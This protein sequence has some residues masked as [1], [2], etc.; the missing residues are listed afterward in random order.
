MPELEWYTWLEMLKQALTPEQE[1]GTLSEQE[2]T[3]LVA[4][5]RQQ[6]YP[7]RATGTA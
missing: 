5:L 7:S 2:L 4:Q 6:V 1:L 3:A